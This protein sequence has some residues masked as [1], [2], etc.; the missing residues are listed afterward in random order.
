MTRILMFGL[1]V[2]VAAAAAVRS[3]SPCATSRWW[4]AA[5][6]PSARS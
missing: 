3:F 1:L 6:A 4:C 2:I 5:S